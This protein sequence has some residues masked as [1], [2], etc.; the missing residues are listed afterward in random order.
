MRAVVFHRPGD[1]RSVLAIEDAPEPSAG[2]GEV[3]VAVEAR[4]I[5]PADLSF[6]RGQY[7]IRPRLPQIAGLEGAGRVV[8][9]GAGAEKLVGARVAFRWPGAWAEHVAVP[10][11]RVHVVPERV[12]VEHAAQFSL[13]PVTAWALLDEIEAQAPEWIALTA[14]SSS[15]SHLVAGLARERGLRVLGIVRGETERQGARHAIVGDG[16]HLEERI[17]ELTGGRGLSALLDSVGGAVVERLF[18]LLAAGATVVA[19][20]TASDTP[21][22]IRN[23]TLVYSN[24]TW[25]GF[26]IDRW[27]TRATPDKRERMVGDLW[28]RIESGALEL[29]VDSRFD[30]ADFA[31]ALDRVVAGKPRGKVLLR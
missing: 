9:A 11:A 10:A 6:I 1:P 15:V 7:R 14:G 30:L 19:Y 24:L 25:K 31:R 4:P 28:T 5:N 17:R 21:I 8:S 16:P 26:G 22:A 23:S 18:P 12:D 27:L 29:P 2:G 3:V 20:G 13:N